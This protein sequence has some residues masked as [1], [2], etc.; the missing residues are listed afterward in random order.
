MSAP[1]RFRRLTDT[2]GSIPRP[3]EETD[4]YY[5]VDL[6]MNLQV[7]ESYGAPLESHT[8]VLSGDNSSWASCWY[9]AFL[10]EAVTWDKWDE[11]AMTERKAAYL[12]CDGTIE[13]TS[14]DPE[15]G[16][17]GTITDAVFCEVDEDVVPVED[18]S[19]LCFDSIEFSAEW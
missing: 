9:C 14:I 1:F 12:G 6:S 15:H 18:G 3:I 19:R 11:W 17:A 16:I 5:S 4:Q 7:W 10:D 13:I 2:A 8:D